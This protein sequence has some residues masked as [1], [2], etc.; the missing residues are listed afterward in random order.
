LIAEV[1]SPDGT[2]SR[3]RYYKLSPR[4]KAALAEESGRMERA[5]KLLLRKPASAS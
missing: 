4:G 1:P 5:L 2:D 3:R